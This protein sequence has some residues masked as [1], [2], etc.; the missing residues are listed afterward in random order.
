MGAR[1]RRFAEAFERV[2][3]GL[4]LV[5][6]LKK[7]TGESDEEIKRKVASSMRYL[8]EHFLAEA[9]VVRDTVVCGESSRAQLD[10]IGLYNWLHIRKFLKVADIILSPKGLP[11]GP[12]SSKKHC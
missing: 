12:S 11:A 8:D 7:A 2:S 4:T 1:G 10:Q 9:G 3:K 5:E 6:A